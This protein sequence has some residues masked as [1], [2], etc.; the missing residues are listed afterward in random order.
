MRKSRASTSTFPSRTEACSEKLL[1]NVT[2]DGKLDHIVLY[3]VAPVLT[4][5]LTPQFLKPSY[6]SN[7]VFCDGRG[8]RKPIRG[9][10]AAASLSGGLE[11]LV[12]GL[13][14]ALDMAPLKANVVNPGETETELRGKTVE[15]RK[16]TIEY[17]AQTVLSGRAGSPGGVAEAFIYLVRDSKIM[18]VSVES[19]GGM[20]VK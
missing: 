13:A 2:A 17:M 12:R 3:F 11:G 15:E 14:L 10:P 4:A 6:A 18:G 7:L 5:K 19:S 9:W 20:I 16:R 1:T 8:F